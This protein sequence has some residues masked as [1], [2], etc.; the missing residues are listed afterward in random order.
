MSSCVLI[1][2][3]LQKQVVGPI[4]FMKKEKF[5]TSGILDTEITDTNQ[6]TNFKGHWEMEGKV[7]SIAATWCTC[8]HGAEATVCNMH[9][10]TKMPGHGESEV[11]CR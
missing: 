11:R 5:E 6:D 8:L 1:Q 7:F 2:F 4:W 3:Y 9:K 10:A